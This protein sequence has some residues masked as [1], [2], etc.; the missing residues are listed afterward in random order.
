MPTNFK[1]RE[2]HTTQCDAARG[3]QTMG[4]LVKVA[5]YEQRMQAKTT[6]PQRDA[7]FNS[8]PQAGWKREWKNTTSRKEDSST[9]VD[10]A[11]VDEQDWLQGSRKC[12]DMRKAA[13]TMKAAGYPGNASS[14]TGDTRKAVPIMK[15]AEYPGSASS[16]RVTVDSPTGDLTASAKEAARILPS[17]PALPAQ[18]SRSSFQNYVTE[19]DAAVKHALLQ[20]SM[21]D[22][23]DALR[24]YTEELAQALR[25]LSKP[26]PAAQKT[27]ICEAMAPVWD[28]RS[29]S[30]PTTGAPLDLR[31]L[32]DALEALRTCCS[33]D[34]VT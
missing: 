9:A 17:L 8:E 7:S 21:R 15:A 22:D 3:Q 2:K 5:Q 6:T 20:P 32:T 25:A 4:R 33:S 11:V 19:V 26:A 23:T 14:S 18:V 24:H 16:S 12:F 27:K 28:M 29:N 10:A 31:V 30:A 34:G 13:P 1:K